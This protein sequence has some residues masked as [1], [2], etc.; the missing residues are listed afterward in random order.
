M[1]H[2]FCAVKM[3]PKLHFS[4]NVKDCH[5][6]M[7]HFSEWHVISF[8]QFSGTCHVMNTQK[9]AILADLR[10]SFYMDGYPKVRS[11]TKHNNTKHTLTNMR[12]RRPTRQLFCPLPP[13]VGQWCHQHMALRL[14]KYPSMVSGAGFALDVV[15]SPILGAIQ[16]PPKNQRDRKE[17]GLMATT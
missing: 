4:Q 7:N 16:R 2:T 11:S 10:S 13:W 3:Q 9:L 15:G 17:V 1:H 14:P 6:S 5:F 12:C 8:G